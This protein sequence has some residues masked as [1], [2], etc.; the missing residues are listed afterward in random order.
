[1]KITWLGHSCFVL[2]SGGYRLMLDPYHEVDGLPDIE[3]EA[4]EVLCSHGHHDHAYVERIHLLGGVSPFDCQEVETWHDDEEGRL[5]GKNIVRRLTAEGLHVV[6][7]GDL[8]HLLSQQQV[9]ALT[10]CDV[11]LLPIGGTYT[12]DS[13]GAKAVAEQLQPRVVIP[14]H[15]R[16]GQQGYPVL[17]TLSDFLGL[18]PEDLVRR[19]DSNTFFAEGELPRQIAVLRYEA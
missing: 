19:Y 18:F 9:E 2:E 1:M 12:V 16:D 8:G 11:L 13:A 6:H 3:G 4:N 14:M 15:Y 17:Q 5:R 10:P 7:L